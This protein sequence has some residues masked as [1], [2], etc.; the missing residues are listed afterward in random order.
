MTKRERTRSMPTRLMKRILVI[1]KKDGQRALTGNGRGVLPRARVG[2]KVVCTF[3]WKGE[4]YEEPHHR[5][6]PWQL[7]RVQATPWAR[8]KRVDR[9]T[10]GAARSRRRAGLAAVCMQHPRWGPRTRDVR[11]TYMTVVCRSRRRTHVGTSDV[12][13]VWTDRSRRAVG[14]AW[15]PATCDWG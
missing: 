12:A 15:W 9:G 10:A 14:A 2:I 5:A 13:V 3:L 1:N 6:D 4:E 7:G 11:T 8:Q